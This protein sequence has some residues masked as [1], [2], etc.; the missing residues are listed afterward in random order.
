MSVNSVPNKYEMFQLYYYDK[1]NKWLSI[2]DAMQYY[3]DLDNETRADFEK[4]YKDETGYEIIS[5]N[6]YGLDR[7]VNSS[8]TDKDAKD[9]DHNPTAKVI[10]TKKV[11][12]KKV[13]KTTVN[14]KVV[15]T[16]EKKDGKVVWTTKDV[17]V[18][19]S[20]LSTLNKANIG[21]KATMEAIAKRRGVILDPV[22][23]AYSAEEIMAMYNDGV[24]I[25]QD[26][27]DLA[28]TELQ[29][30]PTANPDDEEGIDA[31][32]ETSEKEPFL[33]LIPIAKEKI[34]KCEE[35]ND[36][37][38]K[39]ISDLVPEQQKQEK[40]A[41]D[42]FKKQRE[43]LDEYQ[44][45]VKEYTKLQKKIENGETLTE[46]E[47]KRYED[48]SKVLGAQKD[49]ADSF[50]LDKAE[51]TK[52]LND[53]NILAVL[54]EK[55]A[56]ETIEVGDEL[57][58][59]TSKTNYKATK[60]SL[61]PQLGAAAMW[62]LADY[63]M[64]MGKAVGKDAVDIGNDTKEY[65][66]QTQGSVDGIADTLDIKDGLASK[67]AI[68]NGEVQPSEDN[69]EE[70]AEKDEN[71]DKEQKMPLVVTDKFVL[72]LIKE[73]KGINADL[74]KQI[75]IAVSQTKN[76]K[77]DI[78]FAGLSDKRV[79][80]IVKAFYDAETKRQQE[81]EKTE[82]EN[83]KKQQEIQDVMDEAQKRAEEE[84]KEKA[85][86]GNLD[87]NANVDAILSGKNDKNDNVQVEL[88]DEEK[89]KI[90][91]LNDDIA[92][93]NNKIEGVKQESVQHREEVKKST[94]KEKTKIDKSMPIEKDAQKVNQTYQEKD[95]P[96]HDERMD[97]INKAGMILAGIGTGE[98]TIGS[99]F[100]FVGHGLLSN[101]WTMSAGIQ[102]IAFGSAVLTKGT[103]SLAIGLTAMKVS[104]D[105][106][107]IENAEKKTDIAEVNIN[108]SISDLSTVDKK[109]IDV[110]KA[111]S[112]GG[113][114]D[115]ADTPSATNGPDS[116]NNNDN[117]EGADGSQDSQ[118]GENGAPNGVTE[119][120][121]TNTAP[122]VATTSSNT[123]AAKATTQ[124]PATNAATETPNEVVDNK[125]QNS[126]QEVKQ[127][128]KPQGTEEGETPAGENTV[129]TNTTSNNSS[130]TEKEQDPQKA[131]KD[132]AKNATKQKADS[133]KQ[134]A[135]QNREVKDADGEAK[136]YSK[137]AKKLS[138]DEKKSQKQLEKESKAIQ[139][140]IKKQEAETIKLTQESQE[141]AKK[142]EEMLA[143]YETL[144]AQNE[145]LA[146][147]DAS[148]Q[149]AGGNQSN[150]Q[151]AAG[152]NGFTVTTTG[153]AQGGNADKINQN[154]E[155]ITFLSTE[156]KVSA[157]VINRNRVKITKFQSS[158]KT[159]TKKFQ[160]KTKLA[161]KKAKATE[162]KEK[163]KQKK[164]KVQLGAVGIAENV[165]AVT[166]ATGL[167]VDTTGKILEASGT[168]MLSNPFTAAAGAAL[169]ASG[170]TCQSVGT[171]LNTIGLYGTLACGVTKATIN[172]AN[173]NLAAG[174]MALG[175][176][177]VS[178][179]LSMVGAGG[180]G[181]SA[182]TFVSQ[183]LSVVSSS[184]DMVNNVRA[185]Q[186]KE[187]S[188]LASKIST[189]AGVGS[190]VT[191]VAGSFGNFAQSGT[192]SKVAKIGTAVGTALSSTSQMM[193]T[194][195]GE[196]KAAN[197][198]GMVG[199][200][201]NTVSSVASIAGAKKDQANAKATA[202][203]EAQENKDRQAAKESLD[204]Q[205]AEHM[206][207]MN[208]ERVAMMREMEAEFNG[209][210]QP[211]T[212][213]QEPTA[214]SSTSSNST[215]SE[216]PKY[217]AAPTEDSQY[218]GDKIDYTQF[219]DYTKQQ[220]ASTQNDV[221][222]PD[223]SMFQTTPNTTI[224]TPDTTK[225]NK[226]DLFNTITQGIGA[227]TSVAGA[228][229][230]NGQNGGNQQQKKQAPA[231]HLD[232]RTKNIMKKNR[233]QRA[234]TKKMLES[235]RKIAALKK[236]RA[237]V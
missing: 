126:A 184:A 23:S 231:A 137:E 32:D 84:A 53:I 97:F 148:K 140:Q 72:D 109:I 106:S 164:L 73:G 185:V 48:L 111:M 83:E 167:I 46:K 92:K 98:I 27:V 12:T 182:L 217:L 36:K 60:K 17:P 112:A 39:E 149:K 163:E 151:Q 121:G 124:D 177:V 99:R 50:E 38:E 57:K 16:P 33:N 87:P 202:Q 85:Q 110:T 203:R 86:A 114:D 131:A 200:A 144:T 55:L 105:E 91:T 190:A 161:T 125:T 136:D 145:A 1:N 25:P 153:G 233:K 169:V 67:E 159:K 158:I 7:K 218:D 205:I 94:S 193:S 155:R 65:T 5:P 95:L 204:K 209:N 143:E 100:I 37:L 102:M 103:I 76:A 93:N 59:Y 35:N 162:K 42:N 178:A 29:E 30:N 13:N 31:V 188:G 69:Q 64:D 80:Q 191:G 101:P 138:K 168:A 207:K 4:F 195:G 135:K 147:E 186:G 141:K 49:E 224:T 230:Q 237:A 61:I 40:D 66:T 3:Y 208:K 227:A 26:I 96:E 146:A 181:N 154:N 223:M 68:L 129:D 58:D 24:N 22:W 134:T 71:Q 228:F 11:K 108:K 133:K 150:Q 160:K 213:V 171:T 63:Y 21:I 10:R 9:D 215:S 54:G 43:T 127:D 79:T 6:G 211:T 119:Q 62:G 70:K 179:A 82:Q 206:D 77:G 20:T 201:I 8:T 172:I 28:S 222:Y 196:S 173:G 236:L 18:Y 34:E 90:D 74:A 180:A 229:L 117:A 221:S 2:T 199:G 75:K 56:E 78:V 89:K 175:Q 165:F 52:S 166:S 189:V 128:E 19:E 183:G 176:T 104:D 197:I 123:S 41:A 216:V 15:K 118:N 187:A 122:A 14:G 88:N 232:K 47:Q 107:L 235:Q 220:S 142:Q 44:N 115:S 51:I 45:S 226:S 157:N 219:G 170:L 130:K 113:E 120:T 194:F 214:T 192:L 116:A 210:S 132:E 234:N 156:F 81:I 139:K 225:I 174:L 152:N 212:P 198:L